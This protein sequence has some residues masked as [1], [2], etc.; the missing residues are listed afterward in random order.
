MLSLSAM[1]N[2]GPW[3]DYVGFGPTVEAFSGLTGLTAYP[4]GPPLG[5]GT[6]HADHVAGLM[7]CLAL[8]SALERRRRTGEGSY[9]DVSGV[10]AMVGLLGDAFIPPQEAA[11]PSG[12]YPCRG[13]DR[14]CALSVYGEEEWDSF[15]QALGSP[16]WAEEDSFATLASRLKNKE[17]L[18]ELIS[19]W[20][21]QHT[22][23]EVTAVLQEQGVAA[24]VVQDAGDLSGDPQLKE[25]G[26]F[27]ELDHPEAGKTFSDASP[28]RLSDSPPAY[29]CPAPLP[30]Q[31][32][33]YVYGRLLGLTGAELDRL[34]EQGVI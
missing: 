19:V 13:E 5:P 14:W 33:Q 29:R 31:D 6:A 2:S 1:G 21:A 4:G 10:E 30:G 34:R 11:A 26:F 3:K 20:T 12:V 25:R 27:V 8:L 28:L 18:D 17:A 24:G 32:N 7:A 16:L 15:K 22:P 23:Q 9:I